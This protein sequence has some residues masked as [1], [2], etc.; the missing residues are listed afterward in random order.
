MANETPATREVKIIFA[1]LFFFSFTEEFAEGHVGIFP[2]S[3][4]HDLCLKFKENGSER[5]LKIYQ[6]ALDFLPRQIHIE[7][8]SGEKAESESVSV[9]GGFARPDEAT[10]ADPI[11]KKPYG[12][13]V[14]F[15]SLHPDEIA[16]DNTSFIS[17]LRFKTGEFYT[18]ELGES[19]ALEF[20]AVAERHLGPV[21]SVVGVR[22]TLT[23][24]QELA[25][26]DGGSFYWTLPRAI[27]EVRFDDTCPGD[28]LGAAPG[29]PGENDMQQYYPLLGV[30]APLRPKFVIENDE[31][32]TEPFV[33]YPGGGSRPRSLVG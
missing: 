15:D 5:D 19:L 2:T 8:V 25:F 22:I 7:K 26:T 16:I 17:V 29:E 24:T 6:N 27:T 4:Q 23:D 28:A 30:P 12:W 31:L 10:A 14:D 33:C 20:P 13:I 21:A 18:E 1:G 3:I 9:H 32:E 11:S